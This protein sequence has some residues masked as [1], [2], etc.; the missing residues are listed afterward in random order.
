M[1]RLL[2][3]LLLLCFCFVVFHS[4]VYCSVSSNEYGTSLDCRDHNCGNF[5]MSYRWFC[6]DDIM[7]PIC[8]TVM[9]ERQRDDFIEISNNY[10][11]EFDYDPSRNSN[12]ISL[13]H[14][15]DAF[16]I[17]EEEEACF[18]IKYNDIFDDPHNCEEEEACFNDISDNPSNSGYPCLSLT[19]PGGSTQTY[20]M[21][22]NSSTDGIYFCSLPLPLGSY[23]YKYTIINKYSHR[24]FCETEGQWHVTSR[25]RNFVKKTPIHPTEILPNNIYFSWDIAKGVEGDDLSYEI[26]IGRNPSKEKLSKFN[27]NP[28][29]NSLTFTIPKLENKKRYYWYMKITNQFGASIETEIFSFTTGGMVDKFYNA[30]NP[31]NPLRCIDTEFVFFMREDGTCKIT[32]YC[33]YGDLVWQSDRFFFSG[34]N[35]QVIRYDGKDN[36]GRMLYNGTY[37]A[38]LEKKY[39]NKTEIEKCRILVIR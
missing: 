17:Y 37:L 38:V 20:V 31:F 28:D 19:F 10:F 39:A 5:F 23:K 21:T 3:P 14:D 32:I 33:E 16:S 7:L 13:Q 24:S 36:S 27:I 11:E 1:K 4:N 8:G 2:R 22:K 35:S 29:K 26:Y 25:P 9:S 15:S 34:N 18:K 30:P 6:Y 12:F